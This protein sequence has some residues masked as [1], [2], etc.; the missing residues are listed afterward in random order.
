[1]R[2]P[3]QKKRVPYGIS[4]YSDIV[5]K[6]AFFVDKTKY[7]EKLEVVENPIFLRPK[8]FGK[9]LFCSMLRHYYDL[10]FAERFDEL[11]GHTWIGQHPTALKN[12]F[13]V[14]S[15][16]FSTFHIGA[17]INSIENSFKNGCNPILSFLP[18]EYGSLLDGMP[19]M[20]LSDPVSDNLKKLLY[21]LRANNLPRLYVIID[22]YDNFANQLITK[23]KDHLY[24]ELTADDSFLKTFFK[25]LK[26]GREAGAIANVFITGILPITIDDLAS[27]FNV[28][29]FITLNPKFESMLG[30]TQSEVDQLLDEVYRDYE[31]NPSTREQVNAVIKSHYNGYHFVSTN[32]E[33]LF[34]STI[35]MHFLNWF[36]D[37]K[38]IPPELTDQNLKT[39]LSWVRRLTASNPQKT[40]AFVEQLTLHNQIAYDKRFMREKFDAYQFF[41][42][43]YFPISFFYLGMLTKKDPFYLQLPNLNMRQIF[44]EYFNELNHIDVSTRYAP[45][46][47]RFIHQLDPSYVRTS[48]EQ[49]FTGYWEQYISQLPEAIFQKVNEN[50]YR[51]TFFELCSRH[52]SDWFTWNVERS[53]PSGKSDL[54]FVGKHHT[55]FAG[56]RWVIEFKYY[57]N[58]QFKKLKTTIEAFE[59]QPEDKDQITGYVE[60][61]KKEYPEAQISPFV[62]YC[63]GNQGFRV[64]A[65]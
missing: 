47:Q 8:R 58:S 18:A 41:K 10:G 40:S 65:V 3:Q 19:E 26:E 24:N 37:F 38:T 27:A 12:Q 33:A 16:N 17:T 20:V 29:T 56:L 2:N 57:S 11:F 30:F 42:E 60:G 53:Y 64:F 34:N 50:F 55:S 5:R 35:L 54:E 44:V 52:I 43:S 59:M 6:N 31:I 21:Y 51:T 9:S 4:N 7:I 1:M 48:L 46:M 32:G 45:I 62:I 36:T 63:F 15:F 49:L 61:L 13:I 25:T 39:D 14:L 22:E 28:G 23:H